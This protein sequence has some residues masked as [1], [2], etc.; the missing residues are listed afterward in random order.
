MLNLAVC[1]ISMPYGNYKVRDTGLRFLWPRTGPHTVY[2]G[3]G[4]KPSSG[5]EGCL[6]FAL[7]IG[8]KLQVLVCVADHLGISK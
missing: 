8:A 2:L 6:L 4:Y 5:A 3:L 1:K 7:R